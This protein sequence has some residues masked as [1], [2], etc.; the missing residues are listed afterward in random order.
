MGQRS[1]PSQW[2]HSFYFGRRHGVGLGRHLGSELR[3]SQDDGSYHKS[4]CFNYGAWDRDRFN[5]WIYL[6]WMSPKALPVNPEF[7]RLLNSSALIYGSG[8]SAPATLL[9][10]P[11]D[12]P[13]SKD[14]GQTVHGNRAA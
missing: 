5:S 6:V 2:D 14:G 8:R 3:R 13:A 1:L 7:K 12:L 11:S 10:L 4:D 9:Q